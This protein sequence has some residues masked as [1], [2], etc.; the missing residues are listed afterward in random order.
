MKQSKYP[1]PIQFEEWKTKVNTYDK[2]ASEAFNIERLGIRFNHN[3]RWFWAQ[4]KTFYNFGKF[5]SLRNVE[6]SERKIITQI[7]LN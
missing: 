6:L 4:S 1:T 3:F 7:Y 5:L 2:V